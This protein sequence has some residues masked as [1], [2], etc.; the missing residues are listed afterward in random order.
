MLLLGGE[1]NIYRTGGSHNGWN[2]VVFI[3]EAEMDYGSVASSQKYVGVHKK[4]IYPFKK[5]SYKII[6]EWRTFV[7]IKYLTYQT[8]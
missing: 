4:K 7:L 8:T 1:W 5:F 2:R 6:R 3:R